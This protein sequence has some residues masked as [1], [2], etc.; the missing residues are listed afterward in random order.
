MNKQKQFERELRYIKNPDILEAAKYLLDHL[1]DYFYEIPAAST[2]KYHPS[3]AQ[4]EK[5]LL[6]HTKAAVRIAV[7][8]LNDPSI[9]NKYQD[10]E[11]DLMI[12]ALLI[13]D[14]LKLGREKSKYTK[15]EHPLLVSQ[16]VKEEQANL[17][18]K[19]SEIAFLCSVIS[20]HMGPWNK[21][22]DGNEVLPVPKTKYENFV[23]LCDYL[24]SR[25]CLLVPFD[26]QNNIID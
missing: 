19:E 4:G 24:A 26:D 22:F 16:F 5:G 15:V 2:G 13:H 14:G 1:P 17:H 12:L 23:H 18:L 25:K 11:K 8:M 6:R 21:D 20:S 3:Y 9:G 10:R 7:E